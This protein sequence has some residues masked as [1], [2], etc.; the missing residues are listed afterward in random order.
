M[1]VKL[2]PVN[3][4]DVLGLVIEKL[5]VVELPV[6]IGLAVNVL[7]MTGAATTVRDAVP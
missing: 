1:S 6:K 5:S 4:V 3:V 7:A 2:I